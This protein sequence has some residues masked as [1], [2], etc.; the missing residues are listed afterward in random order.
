VRALDV[1]VDHLVY[2]GENTRDG[3]V[4]NKDSTKPTN[5]EL[6]KT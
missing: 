2:V 4:G 1:G 3:Y 5:T 6:L